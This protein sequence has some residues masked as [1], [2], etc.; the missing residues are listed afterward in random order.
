MWIVN[1][2]WLSSQ[3]NIP[4]SHLHYGEMFEHYST[5][6]FKFGRSSIKHIFVKVKTEDD[7]HNMRWFYIGPYQVNVDNV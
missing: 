1:L 5:L 2:I 6:K 3:V 4:H 7:N